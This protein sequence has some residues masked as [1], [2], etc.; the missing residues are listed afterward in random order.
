MTEGKKQ[1][2]RIDFSARLRLEFHGASV[3][4]DGSL[5][6]YRELDEKLGLTAAPAPTARARSR[7]ADSHWIACRG[8]SSHTRRAGMP[9][10]GKSR[11]QEPGAVHGKISEISSL[12]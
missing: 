1:A 10:P 11:L 2:L 4:S 9:L 5:L 8:L 6:A 3:S 7:P 12:I